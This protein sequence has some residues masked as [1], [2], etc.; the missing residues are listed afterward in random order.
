MDEPTLFFYTYFLLFPLTRQF[1]TTLR[2][3]H[4]EFILLLIHLLFDVNICVVP[5]KQ[6]HYFCLIKILEIYVL[7]PANFRSFFF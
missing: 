3:N 2:M 4:F 6:V 5:Q 7:I 1:I